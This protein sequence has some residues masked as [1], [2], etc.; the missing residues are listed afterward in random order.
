MPPAVHLDF[1]ILLLDMDWMCPPKV[2]LFG[3]RPYQHGD[4][5]PLQVLCTEAKEAPHTGLMGVSCGGIHSL[6]RP[7]HVVRDHDPLPEG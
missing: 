2:L 6:E 4:V 3:K 1:E 7:E 5:G